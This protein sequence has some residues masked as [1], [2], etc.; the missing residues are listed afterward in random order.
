MENIC[1]RRWV[2][3]ASSREVR[4]AS[5]LQTDAGNFISGRQ[6]SRSTSL[7]ACKRCAGAAGDAKKIQD[8]VLRGALRKHLFITC[9]G[10]S[11]DNRYNKLTI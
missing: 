1:G 11:E 7:E 10:R 3:G 4:E 6:N 2:T 8:S 5:S 9:S